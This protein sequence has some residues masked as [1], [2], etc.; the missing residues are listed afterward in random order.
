MVETTVIKGKREAE[1][2][3]S[4][5]LHSPNPIGKVSRQELPCLV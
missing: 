1:L 2:V 5:I 3:Y 4:V